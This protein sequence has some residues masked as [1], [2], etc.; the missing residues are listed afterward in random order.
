MM[1]APESFISVA[2]F[3]LDERA[4][5]ASEQSFLLDMRRWA[6]E[7]PTS[8]HMTFRQRLWFDRIVDDHHAAIE[9]AGLAA[10]LESVAEEGG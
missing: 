9:A 8:F 7:R 4:S 2:T 3:L 1:M 5:S 6:R 10:D